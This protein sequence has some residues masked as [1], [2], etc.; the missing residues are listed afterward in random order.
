MR[1]MEQKISPLLLFSGLV[2]GA[3]AV[4]VASL[5]VA[6]EPA[7][8]RTEQLAEVSIPFA[9]H[10][11]I[12]NWHAADRDTLYI[13]DS[14][15]NWYKAEMFGSCSDLNYAETLGFKSNADGSFDRFSA[16]YT[17]DRRCPVKSLTRAEAPP[18]KKAGKSRS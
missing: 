11:G 4:A 16:V 10:G 17:R 18:D 1:G 3:F 5:A 9:D 14:H 7:A 8:Q 6:Q 15:G 13:Q 2:T 12:R